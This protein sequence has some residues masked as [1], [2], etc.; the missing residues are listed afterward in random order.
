[1]NAVNSMIADLSG[2]EAFD[3]ERGVAP[4]RFVWKQAAAA[5]FR[6]KRTLEAHERV[7]V[8]RLEALQAAVAS[9]G[10]GGLLGSLVGVTAAADPL[11]GGLYNRTQEIVAGGRALSVD[12]AQKQTLDWQREAAEPI[13]AGYRAHLSRVTERASLRFVPAAHGEDSS[14]FLLDMPLGDPRGRQHQS[15]GAVLVAQGESGRLADDAR[16]FVTESGNLQRLAIVHVLHAPTEP[17][18]LA[19]LEQKWRTDLAIEMSRELPGLG[20][21][22]VLAVSV[23]PLDEGWQARD[24]ATRWGDML[25]QQLLFRAGWVALAI[26]PSWPAGDLTGLIGS[27]DDRP[28]TE[29]LA[30]VLGRWLTGHARILRVVPHNQKSTGLIGACVDAMRSPEIRGAIALPLPQVEPFENLSDQ[31]VRRTGGKLDTEG[32][33]TALARGLIGRRELIPILDATAEV[34]SDLLPQVLGDGGRAI[35]VALASWEARDTA[36][37]LLSTLTFTLQSSAAERA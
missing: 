27:A 19:T 22:R 29:P 30:A 20:I 2:G 23:V 32:R 3:T 36:G 13:T 28:G 1:M 4:G 25:L 37:Q 14:L 11:V 15:G 24:V 8:A 6:F 17:G 10:T 16:A 18:V 26:T 21:G 33:V 35:V 34:P 12:E 5:A 7:L 9:F 31:M